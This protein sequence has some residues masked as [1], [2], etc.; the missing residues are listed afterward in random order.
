M[1]GTLFDIRLILKHALELNAKSIVLSYN[2]PSGILKPSEAEIKI[3]SKI[4][5]AAQFMVIKVFRSYY[6]YRSFIF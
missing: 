4:K 3:I 5:K 6:N 2:H 1:T